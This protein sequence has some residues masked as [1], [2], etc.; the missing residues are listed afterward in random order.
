MVIPLKILMKEVM[1]LVRKVNI[2]FT[3]FITILIRIVL[4]VTM[5]R[6]I[7]LCRQLCRWLKLQVSISLVHGINGLKA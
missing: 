3:S 5:L 6:R 4:W 7:L 2:I 1:F